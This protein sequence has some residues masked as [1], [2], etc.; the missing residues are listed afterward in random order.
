MPAQAS[1]KPLVDSL[2]Y[3]KQDPYQA[4]TTTTSATNQQN[5]NND[6]D[7]EESED[8]SESAE[9]DA[10]GDIDDSKLSKQALEHAKVTMVFA[11]LLY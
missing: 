5:N 9:E 10:N 3:K 2:K 7:D 6:E 11:V 8:E 1:D 4:T